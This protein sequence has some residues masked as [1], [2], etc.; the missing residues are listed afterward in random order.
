MN[1]ELINKYGSPLYVYDEKILRDRI[2]TLKQFEIN[3]K[4]N[5]GVEVKLHYSTKSNGNPYILKIIKEMGILVDSMSPVELQ[6]D[7]MAGFSNEDILY[8]CNNIS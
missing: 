1:K 5:I 8:V 4:D 7:K 3:L 2:N 6:L